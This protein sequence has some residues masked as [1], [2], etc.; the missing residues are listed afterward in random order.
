MTSCKEAKAES[1]NIKISRDLV[2]RWVDT[3]EEPVLN[4]VLAVLQEG[5]KA[6][7][8]MDLYRK[9]AKL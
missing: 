4:I 9:E 3:A 8:I 7:L 2:K 1:P 6:R 5:R